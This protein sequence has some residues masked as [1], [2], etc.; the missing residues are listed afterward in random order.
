MVYSNE[1]QQYELIGITSYRDA[2]ATEGLYT[3]IAPFIEM[4]LA[5]LKTPPPTPPLPPT[6]PTLPPTLPTTT[7]PEII[8]QLL[9]IGKVFISM[10]CF[11]S[12]PPITFV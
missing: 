9:N 4:I 11:F 7:P 12:G 1:T 10:I 5:I 8:G 6:M 3:R 2:C